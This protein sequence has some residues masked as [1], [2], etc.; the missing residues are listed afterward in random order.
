MQLRKR[1]AIVGVAYAMLFV[2][3]GLFGASTI[4]TWTNKLDQRRSLTVASVRVANLRS[5]Y[6]NQETNERGFLLDPQ[7]PLLVPFEQGKKDALVL[8]D[9]IRASLTDPAK[10]ALID[11]VVSA[12]TA[13]LTEGAEPAIETRR[14]SGPDVPETKAL[15]E[16]SKQLFDVLRQ[17]IDAVETALQSEVAAIV[18]S[19]RHA[20][21]AV[22]VSVSIVFGLMV[23]F[24]VLAARL[25]QLWVTRPLAD[26]TT[27]VRG[28]HIDEIA[29][30]R[31]KGPQEL[32]DVANAIDVMHN[33][34]RLQRDTAINE[35]ESVEQNAVLALHLRDELAHQIGNYPTG[36]TVAAR[37]LA[38]EGLVAGDCYDVSLLGPSE[39]GV[40]VLDIAGHGALAAVSAFRCKE[41]LKVALRNGLQPG[42]ALDWLASQEVGLDD[43]FFTAFVASINSY[44]GQCRFANAGHPPAVLVGADH[45]VELLNPTGP[46]C[47]M[48]SG[49]WTTRETAISP[50]SSIAFYTDGLI[51]ARN[52]AHEFYGE[53]RA[54]DLLTGTQSRT[55]TEVVNLILDDLSGF[56]V[57]RVSDD[58]TLVVM[59]RA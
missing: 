11:S 38:A 52:S 19:A 48:V 41:L 31:T 57:G 26:I 13:W 43:S 36:W 47:G 20:R 33:T 22:V 44:T 29:A 6:L 34:I 14:T 2:L 9:E 56:H 51:E 1:F 27:A 40:V 58:V 10:R 8:I 45:G 21:V 50:G 39:I 18:R 35:R 12:A 28:G 54:I 49:A 42:A 53:Q 15:A 17:R 5:A 25:L 16:K 32:R 46:I 3:G 24:T 30:I 59:C 4:S 23:M 7:E 55:A 37:L